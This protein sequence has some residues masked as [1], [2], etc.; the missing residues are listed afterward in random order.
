MTSAND[1]A[2]FQSLTGAL[3][4]AEPPST[5]PTLQAPTAPTM[6][7]ADQSTPAAP[8]AGPASASAAPLKH[9][10]R[11]GARVLNMSGTP[12]PQSPLSSRDASPAP[13]QRASAPS[14]TST[15]PRAGLR[16]RKGSTEASP[17]RSSGPTST[18]SSPSAASIQRALSSTSIPQLSA[19]SASSADTIK[20]PRPVKPSS[21]PTSG[22]STLHWPISP[23]LRSPPP[24]G[25]DGRS[26][27]RSRANSLRSQIRKPEVQSTPA[28]IVQ[29]SSPTPASRIPVREEA[30]ASDADEPAMSIKAPVRGA[31]GAAP[32]LET[33]Q[34]SSL[35]ATPG[36]DGLE[37]DRY[38]FPRNGPTLCHVNARCAFRDG[39]S[40]TTMH[41]ASSRLTAISASFLHQQPPTKPPTK[42][43]MT[44][45]RPRSP[46]ILALATPPATSTPAAVATAG[47]RPQRRARCRNAQLRR[48]GRITS[49]Q[50]RRC[51]PSRRVLP[52]NRLCA[53]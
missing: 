28:I 23:R 43:A 49:P 14:G 26:G 22:D 35:P 31:S 24:P 52:P 47:P 12:S 29:S 13:H 16:S 8:P 27:S 36:F 5:T 40:V 44:S 15:H 7:A 53:T 34:E 25:S 9:Q 4:S 48:T 18:S 30:A 17:N 41:F 33:V 50:S 38:G 51:R 45:A 21:G 20:A 37:A 10:T 11:Q 32:K 2:G 42:S 19:G 39:K 3:E 6:P 46:K 1:D